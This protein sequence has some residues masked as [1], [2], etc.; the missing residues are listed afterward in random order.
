MTAQSSVKMRGQKADSLGDPGRAGRATPRAAN[1]IARP[2]PIVLPPICNIGMIL[3]NGE[4][5]P[6]LV[7]AARG[8]RLSSREEDGRRR[9]VRNSSNCKNSGP[10]RLEFAVKAV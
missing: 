5:S 1:P 10:L 4:E 3:G 8:Y 9:I 7:P 6:R 2:V